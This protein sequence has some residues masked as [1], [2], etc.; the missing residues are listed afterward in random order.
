MA[1]WTLLPRHVMSRG[2]PTL[3]ESNRAITSS[4]ATI[5]QFDRVNAGKAGGRRDHRHLLIRELPR[6]R[7]AKFTVQADIGDIAPK[8]DH[9]EFGLGFTVRIEEFLATLLPRRLQFRRCDV[10]IRPAFLADGTEVLAEIFH[11]G[12]AKEPIAV[13]DLVN[14]QTGRTIT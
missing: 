4:R 11:C 3:T 6:D 7:I 8:P 5:P 9:R 12:P 14:E 1:V 13:V 2:R 10:P